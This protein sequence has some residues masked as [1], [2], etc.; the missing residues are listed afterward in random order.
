MALDH[1]CNVSTCEKHAEQLAPESTAV[2]QDPCNAAAANSLKEV[3]RPQAGAD[4]RESFASFLNLTVNASKSSRSFTMRVAEQPYVDITRVPATFAVH[5]IW[6]RCL[7]LP[8]AKLS[9]TAALWRYLAT[10]IG[11]LS[12][13]QLQSVFRRGP[14]SVSAIFGTALESGSV[15]RPNCEC[16][17]NSTG[18]FAC[19]PPLPMAGAYSNTYGG[20]C[21]A[22]GLFVI[23][24]RH[25]KS[26]VSGPALS[27]KCGVWPRPRQ[28][29]C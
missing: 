11:N 24:Q 1:S 17:V 15:A 6:H 18:C 8:F 22:G 10:T 3:L 26:Q 9:S 12:R 21:F 23:N 5:H 29:T 13:H 14:G 2:N 16:H 20:A 28:L 19:F 4:L 25:C 27:C 7:F